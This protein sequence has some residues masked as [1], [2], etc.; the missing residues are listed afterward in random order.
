[1]CKK[2]DENFR[3]LC[4]PYCHETIREN[5]Y[6]ELST[7]KGINR[8]TYLAWKCDFENSLVFANVLWQYERA[9]PFYISS[10]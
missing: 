3:Q 6:P 5:W 8:E 4:L 1:M 10:K 7:A 9:D 2:Y